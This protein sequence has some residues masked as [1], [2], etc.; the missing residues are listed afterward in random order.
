LNIH[1]DRLT[2]NAAERRMRARFDRAHPDLPVAEVQALAFDA[3]DVPAL[4]LIAAR[5]TAAT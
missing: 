3:H 2:V 1:G 5:L 4:R